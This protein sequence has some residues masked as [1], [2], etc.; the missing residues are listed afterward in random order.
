LTKI[1]DE[2]FKRGII[3]RDLASYGMNAVRITVGTEEQNNKFFETFKK[4]V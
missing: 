2:L 3:I 4:V 1:F